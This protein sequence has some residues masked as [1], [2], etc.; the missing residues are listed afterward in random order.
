MLHHRADE[1]HGVTLGEEPSV[2]SHSLASCWGARDASCD[3]LAH[4]RLAHEHRAPIEVL[5]DLLARARHIARAAALRRFVALEGGLS[6]VFARQCLHRRPALTTTRHVGGQGASLVDGEG[7]RRGCAKAKRMR[8]G[9]VQSAP[10][11]A[12][13]QRLRMLS[14]LALMVLVALL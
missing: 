6:L 1:A 13:P 8:S 14:D 5:H 4:R 3:N 12:R 2:S 7:V 9:R 10:V 11:L